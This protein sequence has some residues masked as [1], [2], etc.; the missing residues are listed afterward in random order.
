HLLSHSNLPAW[1]PAWCTAA[2]AFVAF[3]PLTFNLVLS[4]M[5]GAE[6]FQHG[7]ALFNGAF[8][9]LPGHQPVIGAFVSQTLLRQPEGSPGLPPTIL[10]GFYIDFGIAGIVVGMFLVGLM[11]QFL[12]WR[13]LARPTVW[14]TFLYAYW[15]FNLFVALYGDFIAN[16]FI[17]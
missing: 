9:I 12:H 16:D 13:M 17:W 6:P 5:P 14:S 11:T 3:G 7:M 10:G 15:Y 2:A 8:G 1:M 4:K